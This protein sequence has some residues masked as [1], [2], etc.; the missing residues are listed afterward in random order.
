MWVGEVTGAGLLQAGLA[1]SCCTPLMGGT[2]VL[3]YRGDADST[4]LSPAVTELGCALGGILVGCVRHSLLATSG[5][6]PHLTTKPRPQAA[7][8]PQVPA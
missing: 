2:D 3:P 8:S 5:R 1:G 6:H 4:H 7:R